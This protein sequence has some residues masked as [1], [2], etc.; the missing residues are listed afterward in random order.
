M[1]ELTWLLRLTIYT[2]ALKNTSNGVFKLYFFCI[3]YYIFI[4]SF[5]CASWLPTEGCLRK[6]SLWASF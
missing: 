2:Q 1:S 4:F 6:A 3:F 5:K